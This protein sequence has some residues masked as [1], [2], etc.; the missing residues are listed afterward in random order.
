VNLTLPNQIP[1]K[2][3]ENPKIMSKERK[4]RKKERKKSSQAEETPISQK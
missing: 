4:E 2:L 3:S 1:R